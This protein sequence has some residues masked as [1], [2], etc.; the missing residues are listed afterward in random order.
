MGAAD[1]AR[2]ALLPAQAETA[3]PSCC[4]GAAH[5]S[6][7][8]GPVG[9]SA[10]RAGAARRSG[11]LAPW[12]ICQTHCLITSH[13]TKGVTS[14]PA[15]VF[16]HAHTCRCMWRAS[17][18][19][20]KRI[21]RPAAQSGLQRRLCQCRDT[22]CLQA[23]GLKCTF[24]RSSAGPKGTDSC[25]GSRAQPAWT[26]RITGRAVDR[27]TCKSNR[28]MGHQTRSTSRR[29]S[30]RAP[31]FPLIV[32]VALFALLVAVPKDPFREFGVLCRSSLMPAGAAWRKSTRMCAPPTRLWCLFE[33]LPSTT[34]PL[35]QALKLSVWPAGVGAGHPVPEGDRLAERRARL[36]APHRP[37][38]MPSY[39]GQT[40]S[41]AVSVVPA[42][43][44]GA[45]Q[46][47]GALCHCETIDASG[48]TGPRFLHD[49]PARTMCRGWPVGQCVLCRRRA[50][51]CARAQG[52]G[53]NTRFILN[54]RGLTRAVTMSS[55]LE[56]H[57][58]I[59][60][61]MDRGELVP[62][63]MARPAPPAAGSQSPTL[64]EGY[65]CS[66]CPGASTLGDSAGLASSSTWRKDAHLRVSAG[67]V[68]RRRS[69]AAAALQTCA[70]R[71]GTLCW[72]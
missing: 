10:H 60:D 8:R 24:A 69:I 7:S 21:A 11:A 16:A 41:A 6:A 30:C 12:P 2:T 70:R 52:K 26:Q 38:L 39:V 35:V 37:L 28:S 9:R 67:T 44:H 1:A 31:V 53:V 25:I 50:R 36:G 29:R 49:R 45:L 14:Q 63:T 59:R 4:S 19:P 51:R 68:E 34:K 22:A 47:C 17:G 48:P 64:A 42:A 55:L 72:T 40:P 20:K 56:R 61:M 18:T 65:V 66:R 15:P 62:D 71:W 5:L 46:A 23:S 32:F 57:S 3:A 33:T 58:G 27:R 13:R 54:S 43:P